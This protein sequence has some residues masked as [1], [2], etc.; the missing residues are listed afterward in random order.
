MASDNIQIS[1][2]LSPSLHASLTEYA[3]GANL[4]LNAVVIQAIQK[5]LETDD[6]KRRLA[7]LEIEVDRLRKMVQ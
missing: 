2:R 4:S 6:I 1:L 3:N 5:L 7:E